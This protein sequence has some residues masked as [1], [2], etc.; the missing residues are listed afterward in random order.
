MSRSISRREFFKTSANIGLSA[1]V[2]THI[3]SHLLDGPAAVYGGEPSAISVV[4]GEDTFQST[5]RAVEALG[6]IK[7]F[8]LKDSRVA[9]LPN[10]QRWHPGTFTNPDIVRSVI[11]MCREAG[12][13]EVNVLTWLD[14]QNW[15]RTGLAGAI[16]E[17]GAQLK[18]IAREETLFKT[19]PVPKGKALKEAMIV[20]EL[21]NHDVFI[22]MPITKDHAGN[23]FTGTLKNLMG[24]NFPTSNRFFH[25]PGWKTEKSDIEHLDQ[26]IADLNTI[27]A[28]T[29]C[30]VDATE[31][32]TTN[33]P[34]GPGEVITP[35]KVIAGVDRVAVDAYC[36][37][38]WGLKAAEIFHIQAG[39]AHGLGEMDLAKVKVHE[40]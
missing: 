32:I 23:K 25:K 17:E 11:Q 20:K 27:I 4:K 9:L 7:K 34:M 39:Y 6:G 30:V 14:R 5:Q 40:T 1:A 16:E 28:P 3:L 13:K 37:T 33:G 36:T 26:C 12:A 8:V 35:R 31:L 22:D 21:D 24:L 18:L 10:A 19:V 29:L 2:G 38:L 15:E